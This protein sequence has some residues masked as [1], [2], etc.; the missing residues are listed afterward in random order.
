MPRLAVL[1]A[2]LLPATVWADAATPRI[3]EAMTAA[4]G[5]C[6]AGGA[7]EGGF[8]LDALAA[9]EYGEK[10]TERWV[11]AWKNVR[12]ETM[13]PRD[14]DKPSAEDRAALVRWIET[15]VFALDPERPEPGRVAARRLNRHEY[16]NT[17]GDL[18]GVPFD[19]EEAFPPDDSSYGFDTVGDGL[20]MSPEMLERFLAAADAVA[21]DA[22]SLE[23]PRPPEV[24]F[25]GGQ[26]G[27]D[28]GSGNDIP[29][30][31]ARKVYW[32]RTVK[33]GRY[34]FEAKFEVDGAWTR[35]PTTAEVAVLAIPAD[36]EPAEV[37]RAT[38]GWENKAGSLSGELDL[39]AGE[40]VFELSMTPRTPHEPS[41]L[42]D[43]SKDLRYEFDLGNG[44]L[45]GPMS[46]PPRYRGS[47]ARILKKGPPPEDAAGREAYAR[48]SLRELADL[49]FRRPVADEEL[50][51]LTAIAV[52]GMTVERGSFERGVREAVARMLAMPQFLYRAESVP[53]PGAEPTHGAVPIDEFA[54]ASRMAYFLWAGPPDGGLHWAAR[55]GKLRAEL[56]ANID[57]MLDD[58]WRRPRFVQAFVGQWLRT[59]DVHEHAVDVRRVLQYRDP[60][61]KNIQRRGYQI[62]E[63]MKRETEMLFEHL[64]TED[65]PV[66]ELL[67][68]GY[69]FL[70]EDLAKFYGVEGVDGRE[71]RRVDLPDDSPRGGLLSHGSFLLVTSNPTRTSPVK[72]G[73]FVLDNL[74]GTPAPPAPPNIPAFEEAG[75]GLPADA[76]TR[77]LLAKHREDAMCASC[78]DRMDPLGLALEN[79]DA[80]GLWRDVEKGLPAYKSRPAEPDRA[81]DPA[82]T[83][84]TG[85][86]FAGPKELGRVLATNRR[87]DFLRCVT[88]KLL[89]YALGREVTHRD[90]PAVERIVAAVE[91][92][93]GSTRTLLREVVK[94]APFQMVAVGEPRSPEVAAAP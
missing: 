13:P 8:S 56:D 52:G 37:A 93:G 88:E 32:K 84:I 33:E 92:D 49:A 6:H 29:L 63:G 28:G 80:L 11:A 20:R 85:E 75:E 27:G 79:F 9:G 39:P 66:T 41:D 47:T 25:W 70:N 46:A 24:T 71:M 43:V 68:A 44:S 16:H 59:R 10:T 31:A 51:A 57:R 3:P 86:P 60:R 18:L 73:L 64:L 23:G 7:D 74:L 78:H 40:V 62:R 17:V 1:A 94:S 67:T 38:V 5:D 87:R 83:L 19:A 72:R 90:A 26:W 45:M 55:E 2:A 91:A 15:D 14:W 89:T 61:I 30:D 35:L 42:P 82:G 76:S 81:I 34:R 48:E 77:A 54:L 21:S 4:C 22:V 58:E 65:R 69:T 53:Q 12:A 36:G 50:D